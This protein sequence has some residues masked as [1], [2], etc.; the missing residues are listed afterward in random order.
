MRQRPPRRRLPMLDDATVLIPEVFASHAAYFPQQ[1]AVV[2]GAVRRNWGDFNAGIERIACALERAGIGRGQQVAV[3]MGNAVEM[4]E[5]VFGV[6][7][8]GACVVP[9]SGLLTGEQLAV[10]LDDADAVMVLADAGFRAKLPPQRRAQCPMVRADG[11]VAMLGDEPDWASFDTLV[12]G[13]APGQRPQAVSRA[14]DRFNIIYSS[15]TTGLPKGIVQTHRA[16]THWA[17]S[18]A[19]ELGM[20][21]TSRALTT[22]A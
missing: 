15:G 16:R 21:S 18:N 12:A 22:T 7:R 20:G 2:C 13:I 5:A 11:W 19:I 6:V 1:E 10:L 3:L 9:L 8:A 14:D 4:L 17:F